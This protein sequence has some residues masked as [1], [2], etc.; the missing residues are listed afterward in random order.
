MFWC[1]LCYSCSLWIVVSNKY[2]LYIWVTW[3]VSNKRQKL[4]TH[5]PGYLRGV[6]LLISLVFCVVLLCVFTFLVPCCDV[7]YDV[8]IKTMFGWSLPPV[9]CRRAH[10]LI[11]LFVFDRVYW[12]VFFFVFLRP[13][14]CVPVVAGF[15]GL[16][17]FWLSLPCSLTL[18]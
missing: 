16:F 15:S 13:A 2:W 10:V 7:R 17:I 5:R 18:V 11:T 3:W 12:C 6:V 14:S 4:L 8:R 1:P 9:V